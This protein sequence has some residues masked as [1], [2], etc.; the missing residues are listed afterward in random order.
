MGNRHVPSHACQRFPERGGRGLYVIEQPQLT[1]I[2]PAGEMKAEER[3]AYRPRSEFE[4]S[5][6]ALNSDPRCRVL[7]RL[8]AQI[9]LSQERFKIAGPG[10]AEPLFVGLHAEIELVPVMNADDLKKG[11]GAVA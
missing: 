10:I 7:N 5:D 4:K 6:L 11:L 9:R 8:D 3:I 2:K 1:W